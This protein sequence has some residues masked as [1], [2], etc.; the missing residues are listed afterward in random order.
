MVYWS[1]DYCCSD[2]MG[3]TG[4]YCLIDMVLNRM[5]KGKFAIMS[6]KILCVGLRLK[7]VPS[8]TAGLI[9]WSF[10]CAIY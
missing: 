10:Y 9:L 8:L 6:S 5:S 7:G 4:T 3:R 1:I 2:G